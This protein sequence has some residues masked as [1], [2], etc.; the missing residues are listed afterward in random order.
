MTRTWCPLFKSLTSRLFKY[1]P[2]RGK[3]TLQILTSSPVGSGRKWGKKVVFVVNKVDIL[4]GAEEV[5]EVVA[6]V[7]AN[8]Q[9]LLG[10]EAA[11]VLPVSA[12]RALEAKLTHS[13]RSNGGDQNRW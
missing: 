10:V 5:A 11:C 7:A 1:P 3:S 13:S 2:E 4:A 8:A 12:R 9:R 6:F